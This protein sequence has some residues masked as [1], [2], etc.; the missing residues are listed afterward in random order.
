MYS[1][2]KLPNKASVREE[3]WSLVVPQLVYLIVCVYSTVYVIHCVYM[4]TVQYIDFGL[5]VS[6][7]DIVGLKLKNEVLEQQSESVENS[8]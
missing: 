2:G 4:V 1:T 3:G 8:S 6:Q 5:F 7:S